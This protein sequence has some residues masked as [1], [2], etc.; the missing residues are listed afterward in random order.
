M[1]HLKYES[2]VPDDC[3]G[4]PNRVQ[5]QINQGDAI[6]RLT[7]PARRVLTAAFTDLRLQRDEAKAC[8]YEEHRVRPGQEEEAGDDAQ[9]HVGNDSGPVVICGPVQTDEEEHET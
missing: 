5:H 9:V 2:A 6:R 4:D 8:G 7:S 3:T 1:C